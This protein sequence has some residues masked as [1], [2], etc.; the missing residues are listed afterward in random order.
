MIPK[1]MGKSS[2]K[3][4]PCVVEDITLDRAAFLQLHHVE[5][6]RVQDRECCVGSCM[7]RVL[8]CCF[9][10]VMCG[11]EVGSVRKTKP[12]SKHKPNPSNQEMQLS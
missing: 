3:S 9:I 7:K 10:Q 12:K 8:S 11:F 4:H 1:F 6:D 5:M 2:S